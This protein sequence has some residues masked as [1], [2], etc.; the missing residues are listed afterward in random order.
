MVNPFKELNRTM[1][2]KRI[3]SDLPET[4]RTEDDT[5]VTHQLSKSSEHN[6]VDSKN[7]H[8]FCQHCRHGGNSFI[9]FFDFFLFLILNYC[10]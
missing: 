1:T 7:W 4:R 3:A 2:W 9:G 5:L 10:F 8:Y 6:A